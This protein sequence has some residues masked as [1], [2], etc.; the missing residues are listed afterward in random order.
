MFVL[1]KVL[2]GQKL[3]EYDN[4]QEEMKESPSYAQSAEKKKEKPYFG[5]SN[6]LQLPEPQQEKKS[7]FM[8]KNRGSSLNNIFMYEANK[9][10][11]SN[12]NVE[13]I[14]KE[15][16]KKMISKM[17]SMGIDNENQL[18]EPD[19]NLN[20]LKQWQ[21]DIIIDNA[22]EDDGQPQQI[23]ADEET[24]AAIVQISNVVKNDNNSNLDMCDQLS[25][26]SAQQ[27]ERLAE[28]PF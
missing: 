11:E 9:T 15:A 12:V 1:N 13:V 6:S 25:N 27:K 21:K 20:F 28:I 19:F 7:K 22:M 3:F 14:D 26:L 24:Q 17:A 23:Q 4:D 5:Q 18:N 8:L 2:K 16:P 10:K